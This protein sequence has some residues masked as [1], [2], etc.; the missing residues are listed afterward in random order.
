VSQPISTGNL[1]RYLELCPCGRAF[2]L[3]AADDK[4]P[5][6]EHNHRVVG[7][8]EQPGPVAGYTCTGC[9]W[10]VETHTHHLNPGGTAAKVA[11]AFLKHHAAT[12]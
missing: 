8:T 12:D 10:T 5:D 7:P 3:E 9:T 4:I 2:E 6:H 11:A 1:R